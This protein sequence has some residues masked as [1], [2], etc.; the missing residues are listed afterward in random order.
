MTMVSGEK[1][2]IVDYARRRGLRLLTLPNILGGYEF[3]RREN[4]LFIPDGIILL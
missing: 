3:L 4:M 2:Y 1:A